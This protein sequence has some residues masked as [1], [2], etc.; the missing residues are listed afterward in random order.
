MEIKGDTRSLLL[1]P[2]NVISTNEIKKISNECH[3]K[4]YKAYG[5]K[6]IEYA[7]YEENS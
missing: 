6:V 5:G 7:S 4:I 1:L 2:S 3:G